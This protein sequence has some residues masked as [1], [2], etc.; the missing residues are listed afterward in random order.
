MLIDQDHRDRAGKLRLVRSPQ[1][2]AKA[3]PYPTA[4]AAL[5]DC[6]RNCAIAS[7]DRAVG[8][9]RLGQ[10]LRLDRH[11]I[12][13]AQRLTGRSKLKT[14]GWSDRDGLVGKNEF[15][16]AKRGNEASTRERFHN[17]PAGPGEVRWQGRP[18]GGQEHD[19]AALG[20]DVLGNRDPCRAIEKLEVNQGKIWG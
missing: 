10:C 3:P 5:I 18:V 1:E 13:C 7:V 14:L 17:H 4:A 15:Q 9:C 8:R 16:E 6:I 11:S 19:H 12:W 2:A 20:D